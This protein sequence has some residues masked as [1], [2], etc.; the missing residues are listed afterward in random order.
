MFLPGESQG[1]G[2]LVGC[3]LWGRTKSDTTEATYQ[4]QQQQDG[5]QRQVNISTWHSSLWS[6]HCW[7]S[8]KPGNKAEKQIIPFGAQGLFSP[9]QSSRLSPGV[10]PPAF[11]SQNDCLWSAHVLQRCQ[12]QP[13]TLSEQQGV[14]FLL[15]LLCGAEQWPRQ[16]TAHSFPS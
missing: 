15:A 6:L 7:L 14:L 2:S 4:Q 12:I 3:H 11:W 10:T 13:V 5:D 1:W 16:T 8:G 9:A